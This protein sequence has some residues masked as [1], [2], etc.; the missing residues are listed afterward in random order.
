MAFRNILVLISLVGP[1]AGLLL[2]RAPPAPRVAALPRIGR[3]LAVSEDT[4]DAD[5]DD[6]FDIIDA[7]GSGGISKDELYTHLTRSGYAAAAV[8]SLFGKLDTDGAHFSER[9]QRS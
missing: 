7:D 3:L 8:E 9:A 2:A 1:S 4:L 5:S 6:V